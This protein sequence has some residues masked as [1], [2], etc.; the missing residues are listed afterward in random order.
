MDKY[1]YREVQRLKSIALIVAHKLD[2]VM[3][4]LYSKQ[5]MGI[6]KVVLVQEDGSGR[7]YLLLNGITEKMW[8]AVIGPEVRRLVSVRTVRYGVGLVDL[9]MGPE[10]REEEGPYV[11]AW[12]NTEEDK[13]DD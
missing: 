5:D 10:Y 1:T 9:R 11:R 2:E 6:I 4:Y 8:H 13:S 12:L 7:P 3:N